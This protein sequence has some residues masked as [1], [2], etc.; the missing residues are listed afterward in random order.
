MTERRSVTVQVDGA[1]TVV[2]EG[3]TLLDACKAR[4]IA[5]P[6][7]CYLGTL[8]PVNVCRLCVVEVEGSRVLVPACSR[9]AEPGMVVR[10]GSDRVRHSRKMVLEFLASSVDLSTAPGLDGLLAEYGCQPERYGAAETVAQAAKIDNDLYVRD[11]SKC[12]LC[13]RCVEACGTDHQNTFAIS[14]A[15]RGFSAGIS[16]ELG[17]PLPRSACVYCGN[18][19]AVC[20]TGALMDKIEYDKR[21]EGTWDE[22]RQKQV[23]TVCG[24][25]GVGCSVSL[26]VQDNEILK[27]TSPFDHDVTLGNLCIK[28]RF[29]WRYVQ[30]RPE[31]PE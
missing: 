20:P 14:V 7:L 13:Y 27:V 28:G 26:H 8:H 16:T 21:R 1:E 11:Y 22:A 4:G 31:P 15:G 30:Q 12:I 25:C 6:T 10:T 23:T 2:P 29:G 3:A 24:Y 17:V 18:C 9:K 19:I 5:V